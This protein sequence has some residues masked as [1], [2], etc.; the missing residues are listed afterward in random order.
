MAL[1]GDAPPRAPERARAWALAARIT[2]GLTP[3]SAACERVFSL[4]KNMFGEQQMSALSDYIRAALMLKYNE[5]T[6][7]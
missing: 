4:V 5:R 6:V 3:N 1:F 7:G 2:F